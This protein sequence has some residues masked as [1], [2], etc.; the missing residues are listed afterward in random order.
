MRL[1]NKVAIATGAS[2]GIGA[3]I[4][5]LFAKE[6]AQ[7]ICVARREVEGEHCYRAYNGLSAGRGALRYG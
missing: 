6:G 4:A 2:S 7:V 1:K 3:G 5:D